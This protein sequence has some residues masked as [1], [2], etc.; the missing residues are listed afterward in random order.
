MERKKNKVL[1]IIT[2]FSIGGATETVISLATGLKKKGFDVDIL[3]GPPLPNEGNMLHQA[4]EDELNVNILS[5]LVR[6]IHPI[7]DVAAFLFIRKF[8]RQG[9]YG[10][11]HTH[12]SKAGVLGRIA[13]WF[14]KTPI[15]IHTIHGLP[16][17]EYQSILVKHAYILIERLCAALSSRIICVTHAIVD[18]CVHN[19]IASR[20]KFIVIRSGLQ[21][22]KYKTQGIARLEIRKKFNFR[23][24]DIVAG[25]I[26]R[27]APLKGHEYIIELAKR[28]RKDFPQLKFF[29]VGD[30]ESG[31]SVRYAVKEHQ[32]E[33]NVILSGMVNPDEIPRMIDAM[34]F[35]IH[36]SLR[37]GLARVLPQSIIMGKR[38]IT[39]NLDGV[40]E[41][42]V[43]GVSGYSVEI[44]N[45]EA[46][47]QA[48]LKICNEGVHKQI[49]DNF[50]LRVQKE[51]D[52][53]TMLEQHIDLYSNVTI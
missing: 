29:L 30:G 50:R 19:K 51:F 32:L 3:T 8:I 21:T 43:D 47:H 16:Y 10:I 12:S 33:E 31:A 22:E 9:G 46:L 26:S 39:F 2:L 24:N 49:N 40:K 1:I 35:V 13:A 5:T 28:M 53:E 20:E 15:V 18:N 11:V 4:P 45:F 23:E 52:S 27:I 6:D 37:E 17:H 36:P 34:D 41:I 44:G 42:I 14:T 48:C 7:K 25:V 38:V